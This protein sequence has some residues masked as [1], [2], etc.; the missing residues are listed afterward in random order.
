MKGGGKHHLNAGEW[1]D[2]T[3][4]ALCLA[5]S[6]IETQKFDPVDQLNRYL[7]WYSEG[8]LSVNG[9]CFDIGN[10]TLEALMIFKETGEYYP[11]PDHEF[12][13]G[14]GSLMRLAPVPLFYMSNPLFAIEMSGKSSQTTH[15]H[16][17]AVDA[18]RYMGG[19]IF[20]ALIGTSKDLI[21]SERYSTCK[22]LLEEQTIRN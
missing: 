1:T 16:P 11:G 20:G 12:S 6:L 13:A 17:L 22:R 8:Y 10:T 4:M 5:E 14:N 15:N 2:D 18:C 19:L 3:S 21:L 7:R 9:N